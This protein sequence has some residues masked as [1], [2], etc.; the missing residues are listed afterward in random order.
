MKINIVRPDINKCFAEFSADDSNFYYA[1]GA[2]KN[3]GFEAISNIVS[4]R[5]KN[6]KFKS[7]FD[8]INRNDPKDINKLQLEGLVKAGA[9]DNLNSNRKSLLKNI[10]NLI[11][12]SKNLFENREANQIDLFAETK[13]Q[14]ENELLIKTEDFQFEEKLSKEFET[15]GFFISDHPLNQFKDFFQQYNVI[16]FNDYNLNDSLKES[17]IAATILKIQEKKNQKGFSY[18]IV[19]FTDL[20]GVFELFI[21]SDLFEKKRNILLEG[22]SIIMNLV[23]NIS[24]DGSSTRINVRT[25]AIVEDL[26]NST[27]KSI[28]INTSNMKNLDQIRKIISKPGE[29][30]VTLK[31]K[32]NNKALQYKLSEKRKIDQKI[33]L[34]L[35]NAGVTL[36]IQ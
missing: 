10:P 32:E 25:I 3:V 13:D 35:K 34:E 7:I 4:E 29:T 33:I 1:L 28:E 5:L 8:F 6:G 20:G 26:F 16:N 31:I 14:N 30:L 19:K 18:A 9:F 36:K 12:K 27:V 2:I 21:F 11:L 23:K 17:V 22:N 24:Q 15:L